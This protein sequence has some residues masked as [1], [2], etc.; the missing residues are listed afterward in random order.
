MAYED[1]DVVTPLF[2]I[3]DLGAL[4]GYWVYSLSIG[5][6]FLVLNILRAVLRGVFW[7]APTTYLV[8]AIPLALACVWL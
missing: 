5:S 6:F 4:T 7:V 8:T 3:R 2:N 1:P